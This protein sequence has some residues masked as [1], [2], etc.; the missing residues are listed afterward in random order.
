MKLKNKFITLISIV[1]LLNLIW[2]YSH[3]FLYIDLSGIS[4]HPHLW[5]ATFT[6]TL[7]ITSI[8]LIISL[9]HKS[10][11]WINHPNKDDYISIIIMSLIVA[12]FIETRALRIERWAYTG[13]MPTIF[14]IGLSP[15][16]QLFTTAIIAL[17]IIRKIN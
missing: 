10:I 12:V 3:Y 2:E 15:L 1:F 4:K 8:F 17:L 6:D 7:I 9:S 14:G 11:K 13:L 5:L 16:I